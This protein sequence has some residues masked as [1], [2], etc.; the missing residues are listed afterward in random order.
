MAAHSGFRLL[1]A[2][3]QLFF[4]KPYNH[5]I[6]TLGNFVA[7]HLYEDLLEHGDSAKFN[8]R[9]AARKCAVNVHGSTRGVRAR[10]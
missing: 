1:R 7:T 5:R 4:R 6:S 10:R 3:E 8:D 9:V 2:F